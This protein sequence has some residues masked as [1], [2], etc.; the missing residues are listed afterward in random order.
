LTPPPAELEVLSQADCRLL[1]TLG[2][3]GRIA[4]VVDGLPVILPVNYRVLSDES[5][6][7][8]LLRTRP[9]HTIDTAPEHVAFEV[10]GADYERKEGWSVLVRGVLRHLDHND[11]E[12]LTKR[13]DPKPW[14]QD[15]TAW[16]SIKPHI[17]TGRRL[18]APA[19][20]WELSPDAYL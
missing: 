2:A 14:V 20:E 15:R 17:V 16:L 1:L 10:D 3:L 19:T 4:F 12:L 18:R 5:G 8:I 13:F 7:W 11:V 9:G 6:L